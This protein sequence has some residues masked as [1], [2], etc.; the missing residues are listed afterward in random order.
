[1]KSHLKANDDWFLFNPGLNIHCD[2]EPIQGIQMLDNSF[3]D[4]LNKYLTVFFNQLR[5]PI[6]FA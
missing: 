4:N 6:N 5:Y 3:G 1:M 2:H